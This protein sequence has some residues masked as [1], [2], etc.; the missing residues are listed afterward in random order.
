[1]GWGASATWLPPSGDE[2]LSQ[3][4]ALGMNTFALVALGAGN[5]LILLADS[6]KLRRCVVVYSEGRMR[7][8]GHFSSQ[9]KTVFTRIQKY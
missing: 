4:L 5:S 3:V 7:P 9:R 2:A 8:A 6:E 1:M